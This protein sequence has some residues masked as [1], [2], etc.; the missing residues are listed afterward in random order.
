MVLHIVLF[1]PTAE[2]GE[3]VHI[4]TP[5]QVGEVFTSFS[6]YLWIHWKH[7]LSTGRIASVGKKLSIQILCTEKNQRDCSALEWGCVGW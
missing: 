2:E 1:L 6:K 4:V 7:E 5:E 3:D